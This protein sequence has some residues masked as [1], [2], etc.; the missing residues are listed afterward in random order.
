[1]GSKVQSAYHKQIKDS[2]MH[3]TNTQLIHANS[4][5]E[6]QLL[7]VSGKENVT[8]QRKVCCMVGITTQQPVHSCL[9]EHACVR[10]KWLRCGTIC[11]VQGVS[12]P[13]ARRRCSAGAVPALYHSHQPAHPHLPVRHSGVSQGHAVHPADVGPPHVPQSQWNALLVPHHH[14]ERRAGPSAVCPFRQDRLAS[15]VICQTAC[16]TDTC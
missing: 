13:A 8:P 12:R 4:C 15:F 16:C 10:N 3:D 14:T 11:M 6:I 9:R 7:G 2:Y 5:R 1:M